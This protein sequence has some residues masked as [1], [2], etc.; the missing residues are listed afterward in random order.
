MQRYV[1]GATMSTLINGSSV[2]LQKP[3]GLELHNGRLYVS[4]YQSSKIFAFTLSGELVDWLDTGLPSGSLKG[5]ALATD[6][7]I[8]AVDATSQRIVRF[9]A[10]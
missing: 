9:S 4:D 6:G 8:F 5:L 3:S 10:R 1:T 7:T 2:G